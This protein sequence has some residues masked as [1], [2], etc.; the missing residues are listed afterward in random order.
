MKK[1]RKI[2]EHNKNKSTDTISAIYNKSILLVRKMHFSEKFLFLDF[3]LLM[4]TMMHFFHRKKKRSMLT[5]LHLYLPLT[6]WKEKK[7]ALPSW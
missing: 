3:N 6:K 2:Y 5:G 7:A 4:Y 1:N